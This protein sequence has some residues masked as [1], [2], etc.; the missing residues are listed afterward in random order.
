MLWAMGLESE[1]DGFAD[2]DRD[3]TGKQLDMSRQPHRVAH[4]K[5]NHDGD[6]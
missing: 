2:P 4:S 6:F 3:E 1:I 5:E